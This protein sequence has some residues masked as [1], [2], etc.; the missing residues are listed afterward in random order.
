MEGRRS[1]GERGR[2]D[3]LPGLPAKQLRSQNP[4]P[5]IQFL[6]GAFRRVRLAGAWLCFWGGEAAFG[7]AA[8][9]SPLGSPSARRGATCSPR[10][11]CP[12]AQLGPLFLLVAEATAPP[13][14]L[15]APAAA[16]L[17]R[18]RAP[19]GGHSEDAAQK[20]PGY[21]QGAENHD[22]PGAFSTFDV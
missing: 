20:W 19:S 1:C 18:S 17:R 10:G 9:S 7:G 14:G 11:R 2:M 21:S 4:K 3:F 15:E 6:P 12:R 8:A 5:R 13:A 16:C 22:V